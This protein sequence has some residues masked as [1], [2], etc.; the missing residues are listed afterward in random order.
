MNFTKAAHNL[1]IRKTAVTKQIQLLETEL[2]PNYLI[3][4]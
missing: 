3:A 1:Y 4:Q 2:E